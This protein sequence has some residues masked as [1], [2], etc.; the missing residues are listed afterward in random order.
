MSEKDNHPN[1]SHRAFPY[2]FTTDGAGNPIE[3]FWL[4]EAPTGPAAPTEPWLYDYDLAIYYD[5]QGTCNTIIFSACLEVVY[6][7]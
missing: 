5:G 4:T 7:E 3:G 1:A 2:F 6:N